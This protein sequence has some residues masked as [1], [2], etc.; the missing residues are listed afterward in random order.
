MS[1]PP[2]VT[3]A[4]RLRRRPWAPDG[5]SGRAAPRAMRAAARAFARSKIYSKPILT[6][7]SLRQRSRTLVT[8]TPRRRAVVAAPRRVV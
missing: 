5:A 2:C 1:V 7:P 8:Q 6:L 4:F 3:E